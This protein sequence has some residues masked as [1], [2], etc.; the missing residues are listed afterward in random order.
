MVTHHTI[1]DLKGALGFAK[2]TPHEGGQAPDHG[3]R[4]EGRPGPDDD[5]FGAEGPFGEKP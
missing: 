1:D 3:P 5:R 2:G 4:P